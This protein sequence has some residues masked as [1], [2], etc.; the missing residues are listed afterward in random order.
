MHPVSAPSPWLCHVEAKNLL[1]GHR[2]FCSRGRVTAA[3]VAA[4]I[5]SGGAVALAVVVYAELRQI[6]ASIER[7]TE[8]LA[9][10]AT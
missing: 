1:T 10:R 3:D 8:R 9:T 4:T 7:L 2:V 5:Q 6:R